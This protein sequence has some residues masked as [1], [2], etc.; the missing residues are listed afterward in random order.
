[1]KKLFPLLIVG[2]LT[3]SISCTK[4][5][6]PEVPT[7]NPQS[8]SLQA[9]SQDN[10]TATATAWGVW[11]HGSS[12][13]KD[14]AEAN[15]L[16]VK[17]I[18]M[19]ILLKNFSGRSSLLETYA[20]K[21]YKALV[22]LNWG[23]TAWPKDMSTYKNKVKQVLEKY[24]SKI[25]VAVIENEPT[26]DAFHSG[27]MTDYLTELQNAASVCKQYGVKVT[28]GGIHIANVL[29]VKKG[30]LNA[31]KNVSQV[32][33]LIK[34]YKNIDLDYVNVHTAG[35]GTNYPLSDFTDCADYLRAQTGHPVMSNEW[36]V[37]SNSSS[38]MQDMVQGWKAGD[39]KYS[40]CNSGKYPLYQSGSLTTS[41]K[42][43]KNSI[44]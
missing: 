36:H 16:T 42:N 25:E 44:N 2:F 26:T 43:Y 7:N 37:E 18:R 30:Q 39:Y 28:D 22:N 8:Q 21:G 6:S 35:F 1:M 9:V 38:L 27:N 5:V 32:A 24:A 31:N 20:N 23:T 10:A 33:Q 3:A 34:G 19:T 12:A 14:I 11:A 41:G 13:D 15:A 17:Y 40:I 29:Y 4:E